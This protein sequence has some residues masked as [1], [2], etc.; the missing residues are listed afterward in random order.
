MDVFN[1]TTFC[2]YLVDIEHENI[3]YEVRVADTGLSWEYEVRDCDNNEEIEKDNPLFI[4]LLR[5][6]EDAAIT[7]RRS[8]RITRC[9]SSF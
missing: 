3:N 1:I 9:S 5:A 2:S 6:A 8:R 7:T 4:K